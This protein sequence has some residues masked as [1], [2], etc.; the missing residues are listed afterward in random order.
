[1]QEQLSGMGLLVDDLVKLNEEKLQNDELEL[2]CFQ[3]REALKG[4]K[5]E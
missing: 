5:Q 1:M 2:L 4:L 3:L